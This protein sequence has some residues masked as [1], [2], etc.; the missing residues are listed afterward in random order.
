MVS[1]NSVLTHAIHSCIR[2]CKH[3]IYSNKVVSGDGMSR[4]FFRRLASVVCTSSRIRLN[5]LYEVYLA[6]IG[7]QHTDN[8]YIIN[9]R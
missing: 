5:V 8:V 3:L 9:K 2:C 1:T 4:F 6:N 7:S